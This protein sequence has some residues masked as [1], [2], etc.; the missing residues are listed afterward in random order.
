[1][2]V[3]GSDGSITLYTQVDTSGIKIGLS[4]IKT[5]L[6]SLNVNVNNTFS[7]ATTSTKKL[8]VAATALGLV[9][10]KLGKEFLRWSNEAGLLATQVEAS[11]QRLIDIYGEAAKT[12]GDFIDANS[13]AL[14]LS[15]S[16]A[17]NFA[18]VYGNLFSVWADSE[19][20]AL[21]TNRYLEMTAV[22]ASKTGRTME[23]VQERIRSG[24]LVNT[25]AVEDLGIFVNI[26]TI[27]MTEAF[28]RIAD[29]R[30]WEQLNNYEQNQVRSLAILE[31]ATEKY[32][33]QVADTTSLTRSRFQ[34]AYE[35]FKATWGQFVNQILMPILEVL[36][37]VL[38]S[39]TAAMRA[40]F[41]LSDET[42]SEGDAI[43]DAADNQEDLTDAIEDTTGALDKS[44]ASFDQIEILTANSAKNV[45]ENNIN[46][47]VNDILK[48]SGTIGNQETSYDLPKINF[49]D[50][51]DIDVQELESNI[52]SIWDSIGDIFSEEA[53]ENLGDAGNNILTIF[54]NILNP[55]ITIG[56]DIGEQF[57]DAVAKAL[58]DNKEDIKIQVEGITRFF[59]NISN[60]F[61]SLSDKT[62]EKTNEINESLQ[63]LFDSLSEWISDTVGTFIEAWNEHIQPIL[64]DFSEA[65]DET[66]EEH[67]KPM[68]ENVSSLI[69]NIIEV[70]TALWNLLSPFLTFIISVFLVKIKST[71]GFL[72]DFLIT[73]LNGL[74]DAIGAIAGVLSGLIDF[75]IG[76]LTLDWKRAWNGLKSIL[77]NFVNGMIGPVEFLINAIINILNSA[78]SGI[79]TAVGAVGD[80]FRQDW[81][82]RKIDTIDIPRFDLNIPGLASGAVIPPNQK[83]LAVLGDQKSGLNIETPLDTMVAAFRKALSEN[84]SQN[85]NVVLEI[86]G[87]RFGR[88][89]NKQSSL[90]SRRTGRNLVVM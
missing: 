53:S 3:V 88:I 28:Q 64:D 43:K 46:D 80:A 5:Q 29:G 35:D 62:E 47:W 4:Q 34:A 86:D 32:G 55:A 54:G 7:S 82:V 15:R 78:I 59:D 61:V 36:T 49:A 16:A 66:V 73:V 65:F 68:I 6:N 67:L 30:S 25:E 45:G 57:I 75:I 76:V 77:V 40:I 72:F 41:N 50:I 85:M 18:A 51:F 33:N 14:G 23:D 83:F 22:V 89:V 20:N 52:E 70:V 44:L 31:Q 27:E 39:A 24:L 1:M 90:E 56:T 58:E 79:D 11:T 21:L 84:G 26:K 63:P 12:V 10:A 38:N 19:T 69:Q 81:G 9:I 13:Q 8:N 17:T 74:S 2:A 37:D 48:P 71:I 87:E 60:S 42:I